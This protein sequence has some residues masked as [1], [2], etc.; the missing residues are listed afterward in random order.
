MFFINGN[1][2]KVREILRKYSRLRNA[3]RPV[4][5]GRQKYLPKTY[6]VN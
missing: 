5:E 6:W 2:T 1:I 4:I 3:I